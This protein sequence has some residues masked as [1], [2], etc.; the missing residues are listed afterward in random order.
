MSE[1]PTI[2]FLDISKTCTGIADGRAGETPKFYSIRGND[3][4]TTAAMMRL[5]KWLIDHTKVEK[6]DWLFFEAAMN[7]FPG[8]YDPESGK[9]KSK[10]NPT[11]TVTLAKMVGVVEFVAGMKGIATR[12][13]NVQT[14]R[15]KFLGHGRP[16]DPKKRV[17]A[18]CRALGWAPANLDEADAG[19]GWWHASMT[20]APRFYT[21][22][23]PM[24]QA[25]INSPFDVAETARNQ[26]SR[27]NG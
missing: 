13:A 24:L 8:E 10:T 1:A 7:L 12:T 17:Q 19:A 11:T 3:V 15:S 2:L 25:K 6:P 27:N 18:M 5:G 4:D 20:V 14:I 9:V 23:T 22:I 21:P 16:S 26:R